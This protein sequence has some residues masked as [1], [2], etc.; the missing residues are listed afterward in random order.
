MTL[1]PAV[2]WMIAPAWWHAEVAFHLGL[3]AC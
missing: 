1:W 3:R 2:W